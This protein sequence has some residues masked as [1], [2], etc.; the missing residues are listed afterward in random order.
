MTIVTPKPKTADLTQFAHHKTYKRHDSVCI[1]LMD[2]PSQT[3]IFDHVNVA[4]MR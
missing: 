1:S 2:L 3:P 4:V